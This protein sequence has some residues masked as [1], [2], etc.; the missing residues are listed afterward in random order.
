MKCPLQHDLFQFLRSLSSQIFPVFFYFSTQCI[1]ANPLVS[2]SFN[3]RWIPTIFPRSRFHPEFL[4]HLKKISEFLNG[5]LCTFSISF[6]YYENVTYFHYTGFY[7]LNI[8]PQSRN[9]NNQSGMS[10]F[11]DFYLS[12]TNTNS[13]NHDNIFAHRIQNSNHVMSRLS[14]SAKVPS[15]SKTPYKNILIEEMALHSYSVTQDG[16][17]AEGTGRIYCKDSH[18]LS[19]LPIISCHLIN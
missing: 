4:T 7:G 3:Y 1:N 5:F 15:G 9:G 2:L 14:Y 19:L 6:V 17:T 18:C 8:I 16:P 12:L 13:F 10:T 11:S